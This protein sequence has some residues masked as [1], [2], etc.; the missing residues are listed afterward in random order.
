MASASRV[1]W[2]RRMIDGAVLT[3]R[4]SKK[5]QCRRLIVDLLSGLLL[6]TWLSSRLGSTIAILT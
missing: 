6:G 2:L 1:C 3:G 5:V 4:V